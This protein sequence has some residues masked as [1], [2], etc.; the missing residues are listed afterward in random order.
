MEPDNQL[1][2]NIFLYIYFFSRGFCPSLSKESGAGAGSFAK[3]GPQ[4]AGGA[5]YR[6][7]PDGLKRLGAD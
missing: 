6:Y 7:G 2:V 4:P 3:G 1:F 5:R